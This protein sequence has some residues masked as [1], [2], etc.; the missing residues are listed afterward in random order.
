MLAVTKA[1][2]LAQVV[3]TTCRENTTGVH[4]RS[5][6]PSVASSPRSCRSRFCVLITHQ[7]PGLGC[8][9]IHSLMRV[10]KNAQWKGR[11]NNT[12]KLK[13]LRAEPANSTVWLKEIDFKKLHYNYL[14]R[15]H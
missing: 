3:L 9:R 14:K 2:Q 12:L 7:R 13:L 6:P 15:A 4:W 11:E 8:T 5:F 1:R 10:T